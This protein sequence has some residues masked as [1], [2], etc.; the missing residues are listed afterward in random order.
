MVDNS[1][2]TFVWEVDNWYWCSIIGTAIH[3]ADSFSALNSNKT[4]RKYFSPIRDRMG[5]VLLQ[6]PGSR[7][8]SRPSYDFRDN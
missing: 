6:E 5:M 4:Y 8:I 1:Y 3:G 2:M 7:T